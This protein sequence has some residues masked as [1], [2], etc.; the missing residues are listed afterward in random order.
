MNS[1]KTSDASKPTDFV[2][3]GRRVIDIE[4]QALAALAKRLDENFTAAC[5]TL[6]ACK[7][8]IVVTGVGKSGHIAGKIASTLASTGSPALFL[9]AA[10]AGHG[11]MGMVVSGDVVLAL[12]NSGASDEILALLPPWKR[13]GVK[14]IAMTGNA[15]S[16]LAAAADVHLDVAVAEEACAHDLAPTA[17]TTAALALGDALAVSLQRGH[18]R[19]VEDFALSHPGGALG[20]RL[21]LQIGDLMHEAAATPK[22]GARVPL[23]EALVEMNRCGFGLTTVVDEDGCLL[24]VFT[25]GDLRRALDAKLDVHTTPVAQ[26]MSK[27]GHTATAE[28]KAYDA[29]Q[30]MESHKITALIC[31]DAERRVQ[32]LVHMHDLLRGGLL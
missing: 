1:K 22:V 16:P 9:H 11:D 7:G 4:R 19:S 21:L 20:R 30:R 25:D 26:A 31:V 2:A 12:S 13:M 23:A 18:G 6:M 8:R 28:D 17:S 29:L 3:V 24:G 5:E 15:D 14:L 32:G 27:G 10:E